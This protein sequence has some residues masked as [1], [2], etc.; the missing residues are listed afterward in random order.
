MKVLE[1]GDWSLLLP[2]EWSAERDGDVILVGDDDGVGCLEIS[3]L[4][5]APD[6]YEGD[7]D[8]TPGALLDDALSWSPVTCGSF[9]GHYASFKEDGAALREWVISSGDLLLYLTY[10]CDLENQ[11]MDDAAVDE[12]LDTLRYAPEDDT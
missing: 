5:K 4:H 1:A 8:D 2:A 9:R 12:M 11:G 10:S 3:A 7:E 6:S